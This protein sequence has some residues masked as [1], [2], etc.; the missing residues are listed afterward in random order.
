MQVIHGG[1]HNGIMSEFSFRWNPQLWAGRGCVVAVVNFHGSS[2]FGQ[3]YADSITG[4]YATKPMTDI[5]KATEWFEKQP[6]IDKD[7]MAAAGGSYGGYMV[8][9]LNGH[10]D[11]FKAYVCHAGVYTYLLTSWFQ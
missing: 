4:D 2:G 3:K 10:T 6:W 8:A 9:Y 7:R 11:K 5:L 1:P